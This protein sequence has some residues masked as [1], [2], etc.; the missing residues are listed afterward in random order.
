MGESS[1]WE[2]KGGQQDLKGR[3]SSLS[4]IREGGGRRGRQEYRCISNGQ[5]KN[6]SMNFVFSPGVFSFFLWLT[7]WASSQSF[8]FTRSL[9][10]DVVLSVSWSVIWYSSQRAAPHTELLVDRSSAC[11]FWAFYFIF[12]LHSLLRPTEDS[13]H[14]T[15][16][17]RESFSR[18]KG[19]RCAVCSL[20][21]LQ[22]RTW[23]CSDFIKTTNLKLLT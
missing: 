20:H 5:S 21:I 3:D 17:G 7:C 22:Q 11:R 14:R 9:P 4:K 16:R 8:L 10:G 1:A 18:R 2:N 19:L 23:H 15:F 12:R 13:L 6:A